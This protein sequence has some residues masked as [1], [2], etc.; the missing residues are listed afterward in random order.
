VAGPKPGLA[1]CALETH[2]CRTP[3]KKGA[4]LLVIALTREVS[5][6]IGHCELSHVPREPIDVGLARAQHAAYEDALIELGCRVERVPAAPDCPDSV[7]IE[8]TAVVLP[9]I[10]VIVR[11]GA[12]SRRPE[13]SAVSKALR[14]YRRCLTLEAPGAMDGGDVL[15][16]GST[17][18]IGQTNRSNA[19]GI[20]QMRMLLTPMGYTVIGVGVNGCLHLKS[21]VTQVAEKTLLIQPS[22]VDERTFAD[23]EVIEVD[24]S[25]PYAANALRIGDRIVYPAA[26]PKTTRR[27]E[28]RGIEVRTVDVS[29][30]A[31]AEGAVTCCSLVFDEAVRP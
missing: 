31:K 23:F 29:E 27:I 14:P 4:S 22:W 16:I 12:P 28:A 7:F 20:D 8:D 17:L 30:L 19:G 1:A 15:A 11:P 9:E 24:P 26:F 13:T 25:E 6:T 21:A 3:R 10:A 5:D 2:P 18:F